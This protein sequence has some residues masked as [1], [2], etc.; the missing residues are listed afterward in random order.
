M[1]QTFL[2]KLTLRIMKSVS[3]KQEL[4]IPGIKGLLN[5]FKNNLS[6]VKYE[7]CFIYSQPSFP[8]KEHKKLD[9]KH[10]YTLHTFLDMT[11]I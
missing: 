9:I 5:F 6:N 11:I 10:Y 4:F 7:A 2:V 1:L 8:L 3:R